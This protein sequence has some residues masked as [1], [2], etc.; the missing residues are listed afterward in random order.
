M[1]AMAAMVTATAAPLLAQD[2]LIGPER[3]PI[4]DSS[5]VAHYPVP[6][7]VRPPIPLWRNKVLPAFGGQP[8]DGPTFGIRARRW[9]TTPVDDIVTSRAEFNLSAGITPRGG[10]FGY[11]TFIAPR[12]TRG[13]RFKGAMT[14]VRQVRYGF[15]GLGNNT[16]FDPDLTQDDPLLYRMERRQLLVSAEVT[17]RIVSRFSLA[18]QV[19]ATRDRF[20]ALE[21]VTVFGSTFGPEVRE[22]DLWARLAAVYDT[23]DTEWDTRRGVLLEGGVQYGLFSDDYQRVYG[24]FRAYV[25]LDTSTT[26]AAR[27]M[28]AALHGDP[29]FNTR[30]AVPAWERDVFVLG[31]EDSH[32][33]LNNGRFLGNDVLLANLEVRR[34]IWSRGPTLGMGLMGWVDAGRV[35]EDEA[36]SLALHDWTVGAGAGVA[37]RVFRTNIITLNYG[38]GPDGGKLTFKSGWMF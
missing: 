38:F 35:F 2:S 33:A 36:F 9:M 19:A 20:E 24:V 5:L 14:A 17:K 34:W 26:I 4:K 31:G 29:T 12:L 7:S 1:T 18:L 25:P 30:F 6:D 22:D 32:R 15:Y 28:G 11:F 27:A 8:N 10:W 37:L 16:V 3:F 13:W 21:G 23:R